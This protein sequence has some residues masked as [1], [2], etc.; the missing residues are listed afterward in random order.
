M[1]QETP[2]RR[3]VVPGLVVTVAGV[4]A[5][6]AVAANSDAAG[7]KPRTA[8]ANGGG[9]APG[10]TAG[11]LAQLADI[12]PGGGLILDDAG[13]V[14]TRDAGD[15]V[16]GF[17][18]VCTHQG[19]NVAAVQDGQIICPCHDSRFDAATGE[20]VSGPAKRNLDPV[21]VTVRDNAVFGA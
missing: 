17:S 7:P 15:K 5:G 9:S 3:A 13:I 21:P 14:L 10:G 6:Y 18:A 12:P 8:A 2:T 16:L 19:C 1:A 4:A 11:P 20:P